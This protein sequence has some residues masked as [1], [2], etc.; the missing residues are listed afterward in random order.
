M[1][2]SYCAE[3]M[4]ANDQTNLV[5]TTLGH[6]DEARVHVASVHEASVHV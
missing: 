1:M 3:L 4:L 6:S 5:C 2:C